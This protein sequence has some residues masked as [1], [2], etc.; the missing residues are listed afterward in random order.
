VEQRRFTCTLGTLGTRGVLAVVAVALAMSASTGC[1]HT[2]IVETEPSGAVVTINGEPQ[3]QSPAVTTQFTS[4][5]GR[6][7]IEA[8]ADGYQKAS[9]VVTQ[10]EWFLWPAIVAVTPLLGV[11]FIVIPFI[12]PVITVGWA[13]ITS[14]TLLSLVFLQKYPERVKLKMRAKLP[15]DPFVPTDTW[16]IPEDMDPNPPP[17]PDK[18]APPEDPSKPLEQPPQPEG[19]NPV[20]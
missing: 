7:Y 4:T 20:P 2:M 16:L 12:G 6:L 3:G 5:G 14:P 15:T 9:L 17:L 13:V 8:E 1:A 11:P 10:S 19:G 18:A